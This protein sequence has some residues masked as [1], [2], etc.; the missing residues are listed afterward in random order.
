MIKISNTILLKEDELTF[1]YIL[2]SGPGGQNV[3]KV[4]TAAQ[5][6]FDVKHSSSLPDDVKGRLI[7]L[8][9]RRVTSDGVLIITA[10][11]YRTQEGN[12]QD[13]IGRLIDLIRQ[14]S[15]KPKARKK[16]KP[17]LAEKKRRLEGKLRQ[18]RKKHLRQ[19]VREW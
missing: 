9:G 8:A 2:A 7:K 1:K 11:R 13:A 17:S 18:A 10:R 5:M 16:T 12:R 3:N 4:A 19:P 6:R 15:V 14:A